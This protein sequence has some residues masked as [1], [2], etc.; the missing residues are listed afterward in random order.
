LTLQQTVKRQLQH[1][2][3]T[4]DV[5]GQASTEDVTRDLIRSLRVLQPQDIAISHTLP[6]SYAL[7]ETDAVVC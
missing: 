1:G 6:R 2:P 3:K 5:G 7:G 4:P